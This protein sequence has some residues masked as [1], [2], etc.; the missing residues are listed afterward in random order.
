MALQTAEPV[1]PELRDC[2][3]VV[4]ATPDAVRALLRR[5]LALTE[6][7]R[8]RDPWFSAGEY[9]AFRQEELQT[10]AFR[11]ARAGSLSELELLVRRHAATL[12]SGLFLILDA[13]AETVPPH[14][15]R[16]ILP[17]STQ[18]SCAPLRRPDWAESDA[19]VRELSSSSSSSMCDLLKATDEMVRLAGQ[20]P[21]WPALEVVESWYRQ[22]AGAIDESTGQLEHS[23]ALLDLG[24]QKG[25]RGLEQLLLD[26]ADLHAVVYTGASPSGQA[27]GIAAW[28]GLG[29]YEH[30]ELLLQTSTVDALVPRLLEV[31]LPFLRRQHR[32][33]RGVKQGAMLARWLLSA[34]V[35]GQLA[36]CTSILAA[37]STSQQLE[38]VLGSPAEVAELA[39]QCLYA[40]PAMDCWDDM[41]T[42]LRAVE[43]PRPNEGGVADNGG[44]LVAANRVGQPLWTE[45]EGRA[46][47]AS[48]RLNGALGRVLRQGHFH[49]PVKAASTALTAP[50]SGGSS[51]DV[52]FV[53]EKLA[54]ARSHVPKPVAFVAGVQEDE[55]DV[56]KLLRQVLASFA[57]EQPPRSDTQWATLW[58]DLGTLRAAG[59]ATPTDVHYPL[60]EYCRALLRAGRFGLA[61]PHLRGGAS[62][63]VDRAEQLVLGAARD[64][65]YS[66]PSLDAQAVVKARQ[67]LALLPESEAVKAESLLVHA[68]MEELPARGVTLLPV[69]F[70]QLRTPLDTIAMVLAA[71][72]DNYR[73]PD[74]LV[75]LAAHLGLTSKED[76]MQV[77]NIIARHA[78]AQGDDAQATE[79]CLR[80]VE[81]G[82]AAI[83][84]LAAALARAPLDEIGSDTSLTARKRLLG[85]AL[86]HCGDDDVGSLL[87]AWQ[88]ADLAL[89]CHTEALR[90]PIP[91]MGRVVEL[92]SGPP[93]KDIGAPE[94][95]EELQRLLGP[96]L[97]QRLSSLARQPSERLSPRDSDTMARVA[98]QALASSQG[99][100][101]DL[102]YLTLARAALLRMPWGRARDNFSLAY[103]LAVRDSSAAADVLDKEVDRWI[104]EGGQNAWH[105]ARMAI[106]FSNV[107]YGVASVT[108]ADEVDLLVSGGSPE[109]PRSLT[110]EIDQ[111]A[112]SWKQRASKWES[113]LKACVDASKLENALPGVDTNR[114]AAGDREYVQQTVLSL[115]GPAYLDDPSALDKAMVLAT[116]Y[117][118]PRWEVAM[119]RVQT[120]LLSDW[121]I[122][123]IREEVGTWRMELLARPTSLLQRLREFVYPNVLGTDHTRLSC[124]LHL[125]AD[126]HEASKDDEAGRQEGSMEAAALFLRD[127]DMCIA[128]SV[129]AP[130]LDFKKLEGLEGPNLKEALPEIKRHVTTRNVQELAGIVATI[131]TGTGLLSE[132]DV[133][134]ALVQKCLLDVPW[135]EFPEQSLKRRRLAE[136]YEACRICSQHLGDSARMDLTQL[137]VRESMPT[138]ASVGALSRGEE[139]MMLALWSQVLGDEIRWSTSDASRQRV[140]A[141]ATC[142]Q[143][144]QC[145]Q[146]LL[147]EAKLSSHQARATLLA[148]GREVLGD[149]TE[150]DLL[151]VMLRTGI[152][153]NAV[154]QM[155]AQS[156]DMPGPASENEA[157]LHPADAPSSST[158]EGK[159]QDRVWSLYRH[160]LDACIQDWKVAA[161]TGSQKGEQDASSGLA[162]LLGCLKAASPVPGL[163]SLQAHAWETLQRVVADPQVSLRMR[164][165]VLEL[166]K[167]IHDNKGG[168]GGLWG[169]WSPV[170]GTPDPRSTG[171]AAEGAVGDSGRMGLLFLK[172]ADLITSVSPSAEIRPE[173]LASASAAEELFMRLRGDSSQASRTLA[174]LALLELWGT[175][176]GSS[177]VQAPHMDDR[178]AKSEADAGGGMSNNGARGGSEGHGVQGDAAVADGQE[179]W[180]GMAN[181]EAANEGWE[182]V[183]EGSPESD[184]EQEA[185]EAGSRGGEGW[186]EAWEG[187]DEDELHVISLHRCWEA[188]MLDL[189]GAGLAKEVVRILDAG[190]AGSTKLCTE[191]PADSPPLLLTAN[192]AERVASRAR[193]AGG[194]LMAA[195]VALLL[196][197]DALS[198][199]A[200][201]SLRDHLRSTSQAVWT[202]EGENV[203]SYE[204]DEELLVALLASGRLHSAAVDA[205]FFSFICH[206]LA[207][208]AWS[209]HGADGSSLPAAD[210]HLHQDADLPLP[211]KP[212]IAAVVFPYFVAELVASR[213]PSLAGSL[214]LQFLGVPLALATWASS[215]CALQRYLKQELQVLD[216]QTN[217]QIDK[218]ADPCVLPGCIARLRG[219]LKVLLAVAL[220]TIL[221]E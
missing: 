103:L 75:A 20:A 171:D 101:P 153:V 11:L 156:D 64:Y 108:T 67:C 118:V 88:E 200:V 203:M 213:L 91:D 83:W 36:L 93:A 81:Q 74:G 55:A 69:Q 12:G 185:D 195:K 111:G 35:R 51:G 19:A 40:C 68:L 129:S 47:Q 113:W 29:T 130:G 65:L 127:A 165:R 190:P 85:F 214:V 161:G 44:L 216:S 140:A 99:A 188:I 145:V 59:L 62:L 143:D 94:A 220:R 126:S 176:F 79:L 72:P 142:L 144:W 53:R 148:I 21:P 26:V 13:I 84:D 33:G 97:S 158:G 122:A 206:Q 5:G 49:A 194:P 27:L 174:L 110:G 78:A 10:V 168:E 149:G 14:R 131:F 38:A 159:G 208:L 157:F 204:V 173:D 210:S 82:Y 183:E 34:A 61:R 201:S 155:A 152:T 39:L 3:E 86:A 121:Q 90:E 28:Q 16:N 112:W 178:E 41:D 2:L 8:D 120:V 30:F 123:D 150:A 221:D 192:E 193:D 212:A 4:P 42:L 70:R 135:H 109:E 45:L 184:V 119:G 160:E 107:Q 46:E 136:G 187:F 154:L 134:L 181:E 141:H 197:Y 209:L 207:P 175:S 117:G 186:G 89:S 199:S 189:L 17:G 32:T 217:Y 105:A 9:M 71:S 96:F 137:I 166:L 60:A 211:S 162:S 15:F 57:R 43:P 50:S 73:D 104:S 98:L 177:T 1:G 48:S 95:V 102:V 147:G 198:S 172:S 116:S 191:V 132:Q 87:A 7:C 114:F 164:I 24:I 76:Q 80:L 138:A 182:G 56:R 63:G 180:E 125:L 218:L 52:G 196:P 22:R 106:F 100:A 133:N 170:T 128:L 58:H 139:E 219:G 205:T 167:S 151:S 77:M 146:E 215:T 92:P 179:G 25:L 66:A 31:A 18:P 163:Q 115:T 37:A 23:M 202:R 6:P 169:M 124:V 54:L